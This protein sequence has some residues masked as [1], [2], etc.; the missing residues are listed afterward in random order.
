MNADDLRAVLLLRAIESAAAAAVTDPAAID[1]SRSTAAHADHADHTDWAG[2]EARRR[3]GEAASPEAWLAERARL[4][5]ARLAEQQPAWRPVLDGAR[6]TT[7]RGWA[8]AGLL[9]AALLGAMGEQFGSSRFI[10]LLAPPLL[11]LLFWNLGIYVLLVLRALRPWRAGT[12]AAPPKG[13]L[14]RQLLS[15]ATRA[16]ARLATAVSALDTPRAA[17]F[18]CF[19]RDWLALGLPWQTARV[20]A[21]LHAT[22]AALALGALA[23]W[24]ARGLVL[25]YRASWDSTFLD[26]DQVRWLLAA[27]LGPAAALTG[28]PLPDAAALAGLRGAEGGGESA[29]RWI[30]LWS[31]T[32]LCG[33]VLPRLALAAGAAWRARRLSHQLAL[34]DDDDLRRLLR[35][36]SGQ[37]L[38]M[39]VLPYSY[40]LDAARQAA[41]VQQLD[42]LWGPGVL[43]QIHPSLPMGAEDDLPRQLAATVAGDLPARVVV[44]FALTATPERETHVA[45][46]RALTALRGSVAAPLEVLLDESGFR[47]RLAGATLAE[48]LAQRHAAWLALLD[49]ADIGPRSVRFVDLGAPAADPSADPSAAPSAAPPA[50]SPAAPDAAS[51]SAPAGSTSR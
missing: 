40:Q 17:A 24:Y 10:H 47:Q 22:A 36:A 30:H 41:L 11:G 14:R 18:A 45:F 9:L 26:A 48:R 39:A 20:V 46:L 4:R 34:P 1:K 33:V 16:R 19:Q 31:L 8:G 7:G 38:T 32:V 21:L 44:L 49:S 28:Q 13:A 37:R 50:A 51:P 43:A 2:A 27:V 29:A 12:G 3:L 42:R 23:S 35:A 5:L 6:L 25:D 15:L